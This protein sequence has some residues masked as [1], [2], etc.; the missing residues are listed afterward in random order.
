MT[1]LIEELEICND[2]LKGW[3][4]GYSDL[5][6]ELDILKTGISMIEKHL[7]LNAEI[8]FLIDDDICLDLDTEY[9]PEYSATTLEE[10]IIK[11]GEE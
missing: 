8:N 4:K 3:A 9:P 6:N 11:M 7:R 5:H 1:N 10:L 2:C